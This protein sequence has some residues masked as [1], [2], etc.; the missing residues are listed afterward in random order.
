MDGMVRGWG[1]R[2]QDLAERLSGQIFM[3]L[4]IGRRQ[5]DSPPS[6]MI[7]GDECDSGILFP[8]G[9]SARLAGKEDAATAA[10]D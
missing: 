8:G 10:G 9:A 4:T 5:T 1:G 3:C 6:I 2:P 7:D